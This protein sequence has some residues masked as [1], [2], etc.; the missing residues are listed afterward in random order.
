MIFSKVYIKCQK[1][2]KANDQNLFEDSINSKSAN[3]DFFEEE[4]N[5]E[6]LQINIEEQFFDIGIL[7]Q[8]QE[9]IAKN[10]S[11]NS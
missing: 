4:F 8:N 7:K 3:I 5:E 9:N 6:F 2:P 10:N 1:N 11:V